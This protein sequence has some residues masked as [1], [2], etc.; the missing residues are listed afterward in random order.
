VVRVFIIAVRK[1]EKLEKKTDLALRFLD[2]G[3]DV[4]KPSGAHTPLR[5]ATL[6]GHMHMVKWLVDDCGVSPKEDNR[7]LHLVALSQTPSQELFLYLVDRGAVPTEEDP[8]LGTPLTLA[9]QQGHEDFAKWLIENYK[10]PCDQQGGSVEKTTPLHKACC[11]CK[12][13]MIEYLMARGAEKNLHTLDAQQHSPLMVAVQEKR[14]ENAEVLL[15]KYKANPDQTADTSALFIA[16]Q[17]GYLPTTRALLQNGADPNLWHEGMEITPLHISASNDHVFVVKELVAHKANVDAISGKG[18]T[19]L[20]MACSQGYTECTKVLLDGGANINYISPSDGATALHHAVTAGFVNCTKLLLSYK[21]DLTI[22]DLGDMTAGDC[23]VAMLQERPNDK[24]LQLIGNIFGS[25]DVDE[26]GK[27]AVC[28]KKLEKPKRCG[29]CKAVNYC[30]VDCQ[31]FH[32]KKGGHSKACVAPS[33]APKKE[34]KK[35]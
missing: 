3:A 12:P 18:Y 8:K 9:L 19:P 23:V 32:W 7:A 35:E 33:A 11:S 13:A 34:E 14:V 22:K 4:R 17:E 16:A 28:Y 6:N 30:S 31:A 5:A 25:M 2:K 15:T 10:L 21:P 29:K 26:R 24:A 1:P 20:I 27:C